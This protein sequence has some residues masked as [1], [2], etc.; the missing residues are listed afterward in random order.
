MVGCKSR[1]CIFKKGF[2]Y[3]RETLRSPPPLL[4]TPDAEFVPAGAASACLPEISLLLQEH[5]PKFSRRKCTVTIG[6]IV[7]G[8]GG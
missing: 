2:A 6:V 1:W 7:V 5:H 8:I 3:I 4:P